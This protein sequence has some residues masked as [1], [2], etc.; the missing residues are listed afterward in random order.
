[1]TF[2]VFLILNLA[3]PSIASGYA[4]MIMAQ[5]PN[6]SANLRNQARVLVPERVA[7][8]VRPI[9][10]L[11]DASIKERG[12]PA[13]LTPSSSALGEAYQ[14]K[15][16]RERKLN[17]TL[18]KLLALKGASADEAL[19]VLMCFYVGESQEDGD[20]VISRGRQMLAYL[21]KYRHA[22]PSI[23]NRTYPDSMLKDASSKEDSF[24]GAVRA[25][26]QGLR[27]TWDNPGG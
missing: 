23:P 4:A 21:N 10:D 6:A 9:L 7:A 16:E 5:R 26:K 11:R 8:L 27:G 13:S 12:Q 14:H 18:Q 2:H 24:Q 25:I 19:V 17:D 1:M 20:A 3:S 22:I 15:L